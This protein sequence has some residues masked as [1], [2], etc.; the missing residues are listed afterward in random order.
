MLA[1]RCKESAA[2]WQAYQADVWAVQQL[3]EQMNL[4]GQRNAVMAQ[5]APFISMDTRKPYTDQQ[6]TESQGALYWFI[7]ERRAHLNVMF[8]PPPPP[9]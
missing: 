9:P 8:T 5:I 7:H 1:R 3:T 6:V 4:A 2:C